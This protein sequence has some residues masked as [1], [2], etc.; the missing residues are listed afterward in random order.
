MTMTYTSQFGFTYF[1]QESK[2][3]TFYPVLLHLLDFCDGLPQVI[4]ELFAVLRVGCVEVNEDF[5][6]GSRNG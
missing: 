3:L 4:S 6:V 5:D 1:L 2:T